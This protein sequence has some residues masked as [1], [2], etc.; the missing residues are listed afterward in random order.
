MTNDGMLSVSDLLVDA[1]R[2]KGVAG[3]MLQIAATVFMPPPAAMAASPTVIFGVPGGGYSKPHMHN[4]ASTRELLWDRIEHWAR[5]I[6]GGK[7][8]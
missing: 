1:G 8:H 3:R 4:F 5:G 6:P 2:S 7:P